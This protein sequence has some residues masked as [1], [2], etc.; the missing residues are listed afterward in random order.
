MA[1][2]LVRAEIA[3]QQLEALERELEKRAFVDLRPFGSSLTRGLEGARWESG[4]VAVW[5]E[6]DYCTPPLAQERADVLDR[7]FENLGVERV[8]RGEG[9]SRIQEL[10]RLF[11]GLHDGFELTGRQSATA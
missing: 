1:H 7:Y 9:W 8:E 2:Y 4:R 10:P 5:E 11:P 3:P 6:E